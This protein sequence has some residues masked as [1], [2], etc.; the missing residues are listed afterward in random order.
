M[1]Y[2]DYTP[3]L[4]LDRPLAL[5]GLPGTPYRQ[6]GFE[7][8]ALTG[9]PLADLDRLIEHQAG[10]SIWSLVD[11][12]GPE[13]YRDLEA[14]LLPQTLAST[15]PGIILLGE[16]ALIEADNRRQITVAT[17]VAYLTLRVTAA[18][19]LLRRDWQEGRRPHPLLPQPL[20]QISQLQPFFEQCDDGIGAAR[21]RLDAAGREAG[22]I[23]SELLEKLRHGNT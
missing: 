18:Y 3:T 23:V 2:Y 16:S 11:E 17:N 5:A 8:A 15:P 4:S 7:L 10:Q 9:L 19:W 1:G 12:Q 13:T 6:V 22:S 20:E 21:F 14:Q